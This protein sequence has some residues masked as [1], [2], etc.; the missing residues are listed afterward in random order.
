MKRSIHVKLF[1]PGYGKKRGK[2]YYQ[3]FHDAIVILSALVVVV[4]ELLKMF[5]Q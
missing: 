5:I 2:E 3:G 4:L 1:I